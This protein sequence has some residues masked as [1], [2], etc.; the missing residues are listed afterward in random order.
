MLSISRVASRL[1]WPTL[2]SRTFQ[3]SLRYYSES[4][5][6]SSAPGE[7]ERTRPAQSTIHPAQNLPLA[8]HEVQERSEAINIPFNP[9]GGGGGPGPGGSGGSFQFTGSPFF[10]ATL[11]TLVG[12][13]VGKCLF[14]RNT[15]NKFLHEA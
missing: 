9:P 15:K 7:K 12:L 5:Q 6:P 13:G 1:Q 14:W 10:D 4:S 2:R 11:T 3:T 8:K